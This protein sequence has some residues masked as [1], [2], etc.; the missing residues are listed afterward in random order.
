MNVRKGVEERE[1]PYTVGGDVSWCSHYG[2]PYE[3]D[4]ENEM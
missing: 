1:S 2:E 3:V 4:L